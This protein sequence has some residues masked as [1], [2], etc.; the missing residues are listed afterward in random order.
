MRQAEAS[1]APAAQAPAKLLVRKA[2]A[3]APGWT[4]C[5]GRPEDGLP[6]R[7]HTAPPSSRGFGQGPPAQNPPCFHSAVT[8]PC[9]WHIAEPPAPRRVLTAS[10]SLVP[11]PWLRPVHSLHLLQAGAALGSDAACTATL[12][13]ACPAPSAAFKYRH[14]LLLAEALQGDKTAPFSTQKTR[15]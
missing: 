10:K 2:A 15:S 8:S 11:L 3:P 12:P 6:G 13:T 4:R 7:T 1:T 14:L 9:P 5:F